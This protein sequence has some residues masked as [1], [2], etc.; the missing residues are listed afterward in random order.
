MK[1]PEPEIFLCEH[2]GTEVEIWTD[3]VMGTCP[4]CR[5]VIVKNN[6]QSCLEWCAYAKE[7]IG[8][9]VYTTFMNNKTT[10]MKLRLLAKIEE[11][12]GT[13]QKRIAHA[14][15]V[16][17]TTEKL[18]VTEKADWHIVIPASI[19]HDIGIKAA[20]ERYGSAAA[21]Y[22]EELGPP[23]ARDI[24]LSLGTRITDIDEICDIIAHHH[25]PGVV[26][27]LNFRVL[28][29]ADLIV[30]MRE[31]VRTMQP[32]E[33]NEFIGREFL[34]E[35]GKSLAWNTYVQKG[36]EEPMRSKGDCP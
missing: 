31:I 7:C 30:N 17:A 36:T 34:T 18:L 4:S 32:E 2:C 20:E 11:Y 28:Y 12:F 33:L 13:D 29:D 21:P 25:S 5:H 27:T 23:I 22:Q 26:N 10:S 19:L 3:E 14:K 24:L 15:D 16:L 35:G 6:S 9:G 8:E 1:H